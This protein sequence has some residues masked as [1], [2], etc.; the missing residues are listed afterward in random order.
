MMVNGH[1]QS[2]S[3]GSSFAFINCTRL[4]YLWTHQIYCEARKEYSL[5]FTRPYPLVVTEYYEFMNDIR[6][7]GP[8]KHRRPHRMHTKANSIRWVMVVGGANEMKFVTVMSRSETPFRMRH[9]SKMISH[10]TYVRDRRGT[11]HD[12]DGGHQAQVAISE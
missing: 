6:R 11:M 10:I 1:Q 3:S 12:D 7:C 5:S 2:E 9:I 4:S 8:P